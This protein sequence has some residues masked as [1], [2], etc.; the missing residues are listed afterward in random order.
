MLGLRVRNIRP[1]VGVRGFTIQIRIQ[2]IC[3][4]PLLLVPILT[5]V[6]VRVSYE[7]KNLVKMPD[8]ITNFVTRCF[9]KNHFKIRHLTK[10]QGLARTGQY[11]GLF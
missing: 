9:I 5:I 3:L 8:F 6:T 7:R 2:L 1:R 4:V 11:F 10:N